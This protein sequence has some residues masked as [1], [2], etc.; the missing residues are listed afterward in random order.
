MKALDY[1]DFVQDRRNGVGGSDVAAIFGLSQYKT[2]L[3]LY[4][5]KI[6]STLVDSDNDFMY[7]GRMHERTILQHYKNITGNKVKRPTRPVINKKYPWLRAN[8]D[9]L[10]ISKPI[11]LEIKT[12]YYKRAREDWGEPGSDQIPITYVLQVH[13]YMIAT[14]RK[15]ADI[16]VLINGCDYRQYI[17]EFDKFTADQVIDKTHDFWHNHVL[18]R[19]PPE[20]LSRNDIM[21]L[22]PS[23]LLHDVAAQ[24]VAN[25]KTVALVKQIKGT[26]SACNELTKNLDKLNDKLAVVFKEK[27][28]MVDQDDY[29]IATYK[30]DIRGR[31]QLRIQI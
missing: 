16:A 25:D 15:S 21:S 11:V 1:N 13:H 10:V 17:V 30:P 29:V 18:K 23:P 27:T 3:Q 7:W 4:M 20:P 5:E 6:G 24:V 14:K 9:G 2:P 28:I 22:Y 26:R 31:R 12:A 8:V 19:I